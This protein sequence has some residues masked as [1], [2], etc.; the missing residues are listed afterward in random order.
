MAHLPVALMMIAA[1]IT[2]AFLAELMLYISL[3][4]TDLKMDEVAS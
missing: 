3:P 4:S 2:G 1:Q